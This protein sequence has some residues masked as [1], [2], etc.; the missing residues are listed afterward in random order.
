[1]RKVL[2]IASIVF[3][4]V[5]VKAQVATF[6][7]NEQGI[8]EYK[9]IHDAKATKEELYK[10]A[11][12]W[13]SRTFTS[14]SEVIKMDDFNT[15]IIKLTYST[16]FIDNYTLRQ[17]LVI[18]IRDNKYRYTLNDIYIPVEPQFQKN[19]TAEGVNQRIKEKTDKGKTPMKF[20]VQYVIVADGSIK[21]ILA[22]LE[23]SMATADSF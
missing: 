7:E 1:M 17:S 5:A 14:P 9:G 6:P 19:M 8:V 12:L 22:S 11:K 23:K 4:S 10:N 3:A 16:P 18:E 15:G 13:V 21:S 2:L 20:L